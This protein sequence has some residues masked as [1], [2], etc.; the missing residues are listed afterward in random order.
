VLWNNRQAEKVAAEQS[1]SDHFKADVGERSG[2]VQ[3]QGYLEK[4]ARGA[5]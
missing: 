4:P 1:R 5:G 2:T 3:S